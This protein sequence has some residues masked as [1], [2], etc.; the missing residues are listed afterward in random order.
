MNPR[1]QHGSGGVF[2][3]SFPPIISFPNAGLGTHASKLRFESRI[4]CG[5]GIQLNV[6]MT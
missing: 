5:N 2:L 1:S 3:A 6:G 4:P